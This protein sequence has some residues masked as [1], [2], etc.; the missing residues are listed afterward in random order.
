MIFPPLSTFCLSSIEEERPKP[1]Y[2]KQTPFYFV[3]P[4]DVMFYY[5]LKTLLFLLCV[6]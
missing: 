1:K 4:Q 5:A 2:V 6:S 3:S